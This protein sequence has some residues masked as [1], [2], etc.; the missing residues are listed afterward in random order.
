MFKRTQ[1]HFVI[2]I[3][4]F[5]SSCLVSWNFDITCSVVKILLSYKMNER[6]SAVLYPDISE[7][8][9]LSFQLFEIRTFELL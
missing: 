3:S 2:N 4:T 1:S 7:S 8:K 5:S 9:S 6:E